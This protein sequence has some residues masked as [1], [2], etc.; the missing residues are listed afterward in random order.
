[1][2]AA[3]VDRLPLLLLITFPA[4]WWL[5]MLT[6]ALPDFMDTVAELFPMRIAAARQWWAGEIPLWLPNQFCGVPLAANPQVAV[7]YPPQWLLFLWPH[8][9]ANGF[10]LL[11]HYWLGGIGSY[12]LARKLHCGA[13]A[14][15]VGAMGVTF[16]SYL[17]SRVALTPHLYAAPWF[18]W[19]LLTLLAAEADGWS[20][21]SAALCSVPLALLLLAGSPQLAFYFALFLG[22][23]FVLTVEWRRDAAPAIVFA[24][25]VSV[26][27]LALAAIQLVPTW[28]FLRHSARQPISM[29]RLAEGGLQ[30]GFIWRALLG[31]T[32][33]PWED[34]DSINAIGAGLL[35][36]VPVAL[37]GR[38]T[39]G[40]A[41]PLL[42]IAGLAWILAL[43]VV[44]PWAARVLPLVEKFHAP[45]RILVGWSVAMPLVAAMGAQVLS[46]WLRA[47]FGRRGRFAAWV[48]LAAALIPTIWMLGRLERHFA[49]PARFAPTPEFIRHLREDR[50]LT[51]D[52]SLR[53]SYNSRDPDFGHAMLPDMAAL[54]GTFDV[55]GY[56]P[57]IPER[58]AMLA[59]EVARGS[60]WLYPSHGVF[61]SDPGHPLL[62]MLNAQYVVGRPELFEPSRL[63][64][65]GRREWDREAFLGRLD[66]VEADPFWPLY[67]VRETR[68]LAWFVEVAAPSESP[69]AALLHAAA[70]D[71]TRVAFTEEVLYLPVPAS[72]PTVDARRTRSG[73]FELRWPEPLSIPMFLS[74]STTW[75]PG[76]QAYDDRG[77][78]LRLYA[79]NGAITG[80]LVP[81][82]STRVELEYRPLSF[83]IGTLISLLGCLAMAI[84]LRKTS[85][86]RGRESESPQ[87]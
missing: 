87:R 54:H 85:S 40:R 80:V 72:R 51:V 69:E 34:T 45:R 35:L 11:F 19:I 48:V 77:E 76:W 4:L 29:E 39:R 37:L 2:A 78:R 15:L 86:R 32:G 79:A 42:V 21:R 57:L 64:A 41:L 73:A 50:F 18:P 27:P 9:I 55:Q 16:G 63:M 65:G 58:M 26:L 10:V 24:G 56:D 71:L 49:D 1:M 30:G 7:W 60:V 62:A 81:A 44:A 22:V 59:G 46:V 14:A 5:P 8:P 12:L 53:Y 28:E 43:G 23:W 84:L 31:G 70:N 74:V 3:R 33:E 52:P 47:R 68:P 38:R 66:L 25:I 82:G 20:P 61:V 13:P 83:R 75:F 67:R 6:G 17:V 36:L